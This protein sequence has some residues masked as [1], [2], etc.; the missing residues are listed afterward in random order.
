MSDG[1]DIHRQAAWSIVRAQLLVTVFLAAAAYGWASPRAALSAALGGGICVASGAYLALRMFRFRAGTPPARLVR[2]FY[3]G[4]AV[5]I[6]ITA[7]SFALVIVFV[8]VDVLVLILGYIAALTVYWLALI[9][10][11]GRKV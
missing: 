4:E 3:A 10:T 2:A 7:A 8:D 11:A 9:V 6:A 1:L 5:K